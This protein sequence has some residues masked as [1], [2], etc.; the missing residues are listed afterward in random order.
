MR[1]LYNAAYKSGRGFTTDEWWSTVSKAARGKS[2]SDFSS[3]YIDGRDPFP[4]DQ[5][6]PLAGL[7]LARDT[8]HVPQLGIASLQDS[9]GL[10]V[11]EVIPESSAAAAGVQP[12]DQLIS[13]GGFNADDPNWDGQISLSLRPAT[14]RHRAAGSRPAKRRRANADGTFALRHAS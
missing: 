10:H 8:T 7:R 6:L 1:T 11:T 5:I 2:F 13:V 12:G 9:T 4:Y 14:R 3:R